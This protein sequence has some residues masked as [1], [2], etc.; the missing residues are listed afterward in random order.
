VLS[1]LG[2]PACPDWSTGLRVGSVPLV[3]GIGGGPAAIDPQAVARAVEIASHEPDCPPVAVRSMRAGPS[4]SV[5]PGASLAAAHGATMVEAFTA[6][7][8]AYV[9]ISAA[10]RVHP[11]ALAELWA[12][13]LRRERCGIVEALRFPDESPK[14]YDPATYETP[15][16]SAGALLLTAGLF[17]RVGGFDPRFDSWGADVDLSWRARVSGLSTSVAPR[18]LVFVEIQPT[19]TAMLRGALRLASKYGQRKA[20]LS[21]VAELER[22]GE[23]AAFTPEKRNAAVSRVADFKHGLGFARERW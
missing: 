23:T 19:R 6:G 17:E 14:V 10:A 9:C 11:R 18:A 2:T 20:A 15:W 3:V 5:C 21:F 7:A 22:L 16:A 1:T 4:E 8:K 13:M 12:A